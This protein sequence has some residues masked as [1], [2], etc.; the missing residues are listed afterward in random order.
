MENRADIRCG[1]CGRSI[2]LRGQGPAYAYGNHW[3]CEKDRV[4]VMKA[5]KK[6]AGLSTRTVDR[7]DKRFG[8]VVD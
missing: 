1:D 2:G 7:R 6:A 8:R 5:D 4:L 3:K